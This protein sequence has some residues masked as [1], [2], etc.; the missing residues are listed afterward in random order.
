MDA[1]TYKGKLLQIKS[2]VGKVDRKWQAYTKDDIELLDQSACLSKL[3]KIGDAEELC[4]DKIFNLI[5]EL[6]ENVETDEARIKSLR[7]MSD[8][9]R[10]RVKL[11]QKR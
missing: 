6:D 7:S 2:E 11:I 9:L 3:E 5:Y 10:K 1:D 4:Q 8:E